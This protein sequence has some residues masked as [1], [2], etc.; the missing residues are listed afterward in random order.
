V[1]IAVVSGPPVARLLRG[2]VMFLR[3]CEFVE[4]AVVSGQTRPTVIWR[5]ILPNALCA[6]IGRAKQSLMVY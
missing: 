4:A 6:I 5:Q 3:S 1:A 2:E